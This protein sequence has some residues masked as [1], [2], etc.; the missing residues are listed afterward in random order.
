MG[1]SF[2]CRYDGILGQDFWKDKRATIDYCNCVITMGE[3]VMDFDEPDETADVN[4]ILTLKSR[5]ESIVRLPAKS[6]GIGIV[7]KREI[8]PGVYL[9]EALTEAEDGYCV[10]NVVSTSVDVTVE[11]PFV[12]IE[13]VE[14]DSESV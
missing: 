3:I 14:N 12:E 7:S 6:N 13:K 8:V 5:A 2:D 10:A 11:I 9:A 1:D 4:H